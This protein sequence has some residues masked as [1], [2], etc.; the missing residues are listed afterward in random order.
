MRFNAGSAWMAVVAAVILVVS[1]K[2]WFF[3]TLSRQRRPA[4]AMFLH[5][6]KS[7]ALVKY[8]CDRTEE[9]LN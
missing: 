4:W 8:L 1:W 7:T 9:A 6:K 5:A 3:T 2:Y